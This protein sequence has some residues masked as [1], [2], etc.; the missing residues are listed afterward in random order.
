MLH[1]GYRRNSNELYGAYGHNLTYDE[2]TW[3]ANWCFIRGQNLLIPHAY[4]YSVRGP[5]FEERPP[6]V[7]PNA[8]WWKDYRPFTDACR[9]LSW[10]NTDSRQV[11]DIAILC[12]ATYLPDRSAKTLYQNQ[13]D[14]NYLELRHL[15]EKSGVDRNGVK[16]YGMTYKAIVLD[17]I[18]FLPPYLRSALKKLAKNKHLIINAD[19]KYASDFKGAYIYRTPDDLI[20]AVNKITE[21]DILLTDA[22][23]NIRY[24][25]VVKSNDHFYII[26]N[27]EGTEVKTGFR[28][29]VS[30]KRQWIDPYTAGVTQAGAEE[31]ITL[32]PHELKILEVY[33]SGLNS[34]R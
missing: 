12:E 18:S 13:R 34:L 22:S 28:L 25:H 2:M 10:L 7:G 3:L 14:F 4:F 30:G 32:K 26:F 20:N 16:I 6:D 8:A 23:E 29:Q 11:C 21:P 5:R 31:I 15:K 19:S 9:R 24:R 17:T 1:L 27:E 33:N